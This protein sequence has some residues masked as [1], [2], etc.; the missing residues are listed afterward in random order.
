[1]AG[2]VATEP[3]TRTPRSVRAEDRQ[4]DAARN[5]PK[6]TLGLMAVVL[7]GL[8]GMVALAVVRETTDSRPA[9]QTVGPRPPL[10]TPR[11]ALSAAEESYA[12]AL[13]PIHNEVKASALKMTMSGI[14]YKTNGIDAGTLR[15]QIVAA[16]ETY[17]SA[18]E[19]ILALQPP[20]SLQPAH[21]EYLAAVRLYQQSAAEMVK[22]AD[23]PRD[24]HLVAAF[25]MSQEGGRKLRDVGGLLWPSEYVPN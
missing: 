8:A 12:L 11:P 24:D 7:V 16:A 19:R 18:E 3:H 13:W 17:R 14:Q 23:D 2:T 15:D 9:G 4:T 1:V 6:L 10:A 22:V 20:T 5:G 21:D 25:P